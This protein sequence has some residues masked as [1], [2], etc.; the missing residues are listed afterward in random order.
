[1]PV[2]TGGDRDGR[3]RVERLTHMPPERRIAISGRSTLAASTTVKEQ[4]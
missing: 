2:D 4:T 1:M 3:R